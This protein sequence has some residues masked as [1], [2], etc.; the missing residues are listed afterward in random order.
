MMSERKS[1]LQ[2]SERGSERDQQ[3]MLGSVRSY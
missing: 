2:A 3:S 1:M